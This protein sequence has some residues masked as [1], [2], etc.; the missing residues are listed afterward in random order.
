MTDKL[1]FSLILI[2]ITT[3]LFSQSY[4]S[5]KSLAQSDLTSTGGILSCDFVQFCSN[6]VEVTKNSSESLVITPSGGISETTQATPEDETQATPEDETQATPEDETQATPGAPELI[7]DVTSNISL[8]MTP[9]LPGNLATDEFQEPLGAPLQNPNG[10]TE[11]SIDDHNLANMNATTDNATIITPSSEISSPPLEENITIALQEG[12]ENNTRV[13]LP[14]RTGTLSVYSP[15]NGT[16]QSTQNAT[17]G[18]TAANET[19][20][21][22]AANE[23]VDSTAANETVDSTAA[24]ETVTESS[25]ETI[26]DQIN[27]SNNNVPSATSGTATQNPSSPTAFLDPLIN[28]FKELFGIK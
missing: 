27:M 14:N 6:P 7:P 2:L 28:P 24:N 15:A 18:M 12:L 20:D 23:T 8:I 17:S 3:V 9:D 25:Q 1:T 19:V 22:T 10:T 4:Q 16:T 5:Q 26:Q 21:S 13:D 11:T